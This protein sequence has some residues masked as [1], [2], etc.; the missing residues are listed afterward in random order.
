MMRAGEMTT[1]DGGGDAFKLAAV[2]LV[3]VAFYAIMRRRH[4]KEE[5]EREYEA[6]HDVIEDEMF[7]REFAN[8]IDEGEAA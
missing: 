1:S 5:A 4:R 8:A 3:A 7:A 6:T 2:V